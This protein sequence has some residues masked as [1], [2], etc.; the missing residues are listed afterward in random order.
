MDAFKIAVKFFVVDSS[1]LT[2]HEFVPIFH[3]WIQQEAVAD[4]VLID[5]A[6]YAHVKDGPGTLLVSH[7]ANFYADQFDGRLGLTYSRKQPVEG[8]FAD[9]LRQAL[10]A[11][12]DAAV[13]LQGDSRLEGRIQFKTD[14]VLVT[15][16]DRLLAPNTPETFAA[17][18]PEL[19][20]VLGEIFPTAQLEFEQQPGER[21]VFAVRVRATGAPAD[22]SGLQSR[23]TAPSR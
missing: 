7:E 11:A 9:R 8:S 13:K 17:V 16:N 12:I 21:N 14:E 23:Q 2:P 22:I 1:F 18:E 15:L 3:S 5:V 6:D 4:H 20:E 19:R 10:S